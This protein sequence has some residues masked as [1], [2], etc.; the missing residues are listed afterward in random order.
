MARATYSIQQDQAQKTSKR[1]DYNP[2][3]LFSI[4]RPDTDRFKPLNPDLS[5]R[6]GLGYLI[7]LHF[8]EE[9]NR[10]VVDCVSG[11]MF[12]PT[13]TSKA[14]L[15]R[16]HLQGNIHVTGNTVIDALA[17][18]CDK[19][20][21]DSVLSAQMDS[22]Y[23]WI[24]PSRKLILVTGHRRESFGDGFRSICTA[25][26][27]LAQR[28]DVQIVYPVHLNPA[29][30]DVVMTS[31]GNCERIHLIEPLDYLDFVWM[32]QHAHIILTDSGGVQEEAPFLGKPV[33]VMRDVTERPEAV[34][35]GTVAI[36]GTNAQRIT[37]S[38]ARLLD[39]DAYR[40]SF[41]RRVNPYGD[42][43]ASQRIVSALLGRRFDEFGTSIPS[44]A[45]TRSTVANTGD[46][47][48]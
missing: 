42:G 40:A 41:A 30:R 19:L 29:V 27:Q 34:A 15:V 20:R 2:C 36:V 7:S 4:P 9:M 23:S 17:A 18:T 47:S 46:Y 35:A 37:D 48:R 45:N 26:A 39:D 38:V 22:R 12:A 25:L 28:S 10:R 16:E 6:V 44:E 8:P 13:A 3:N 32:M 24:D 1:P 14:H 11:W 33:L 5:R 31:L 21:D 43:I